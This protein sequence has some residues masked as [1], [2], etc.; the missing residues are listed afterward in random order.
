MGVAKQDCLR[1]WIKSPYSQSHNYASINITTCYAKWSDYNDKQRVPQEG[2]HKG[3]LVSRPLLL[4]RVSRVTDHDG[5]L[6][7]RPQRQNPKP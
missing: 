1:A 3:F 4:R 5:I 6:A 7:L 2:A